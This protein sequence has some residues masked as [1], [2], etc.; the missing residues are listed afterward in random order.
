MVIYTN[1]WHYL[2]KTGENLPNNCK[3]RRA[4]YREWVHGDNIV[5]LNKIPPK[6]THF[7]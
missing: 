3:M 7:I 1:V 4:V 5:G 2:N 6:H